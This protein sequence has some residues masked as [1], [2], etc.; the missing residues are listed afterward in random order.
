[1]GNELFQDDM[2]REQ[3]AQI[4]VAIL[5]NEG[6]IASERDIRKELGGGD[7][8]RISFHQRAWVKR[9]I[10]VFRQ[11]SNDFSL[12]SDNEGL[13]EALLHT[14]LVREEAIESAQLAAQAFWDDLEELKDELRKVRDEGAQLVRRMR[15][16]LDEVPDL[17][18]I[19]AALRRDQVALSEL[20]QR[21][22]L[23]GVD[24]NWVH[25]DAEAAIEASEQQRTLQ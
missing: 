24:R 14:K 22:A 3:V 15:Q 10:Q 6:R 1:M 13:S 12:M 20:L 18:K 17:E 25:P 4:A 7:L 9:A 21:A 5:A 8:A 19:F 16:V 2:L 23:G 11:A